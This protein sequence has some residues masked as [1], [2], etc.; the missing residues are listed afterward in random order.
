MGDG[1]TEWTN[2][3]SLGPPRV[4]VVATYSEILDLYSRVVELDVADLRTATSTDE[5][6]AILLHCSIDVVVIANS[7]LG[8]LED[9][10]LLRFLEQEMGCLIPVVLSSGSGLPNPFGDLLES[11]LV[12]WS[13]PKPAWIGDLRHALMQ[14]TRLRPL[15][16]HA[17]PLTRA[18]DE[19]WRIIAHTRYL[20]DQILEL[21]YRL[22]AERA[23]R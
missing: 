18:R 2:P 5:A 19:R 11:R 13:V 10:R 1:P 17:D 9:R 15:L 23:G 12:C 21:R 6:I 3:E 7:H 16:V 14:A 4:L 22:K 8:G 20:E